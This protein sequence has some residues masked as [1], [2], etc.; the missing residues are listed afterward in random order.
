MRNIDFLAIKSNA[1]EPIDTAHHP[2]GSTE[3]LLSVPN[4]DCNWQSVYRLAEPKRLPKGTTIHCEAHY[5][6][7]SENPANP[8]PNRELTWG[9]QTREE[10]LS[11]YLDY[12]VDEPI[13]S[14]ASLQT[15]VP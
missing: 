5:D 15:S 10:M 13:P 3:I 2:D 9:E 4:Y 11:G 7:S 6:N 12:I 1:S 8:D 14:G